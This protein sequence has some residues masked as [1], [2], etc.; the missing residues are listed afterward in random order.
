MMDNESLRGSSKNTTVVFLSLLLVAAVIWGIVASVIASKH[1]ENCDRL[2]QEKEQI[3]I[4][5]EQIRMESERRM[6]EADKLRKTALEWTRQHQ[7]QIQA[8]MRKKAEAAAAAAKATAPK[9]PAKSATKAG[10]SRST[11]KKTAA[12]R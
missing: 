3:R 9:A 4:E 12:R 8:E 10:S 6:M 11:V 7:L 2:T 5:A 1:R